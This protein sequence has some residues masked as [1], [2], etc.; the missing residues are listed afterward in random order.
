MQKVFVSILNFNGRDN[1]IDCLN[2]LK[3]VIEKN[4]ELFLVVID[5]NSKE[6]LNLPSF[7]GLNIKI[8]ENNSNLGFSGGHNVGIKYSLENGA[9]FVV[10]LNN[11]TVVDKNFILELLKVQNSNKDIGITSPKIYFAPGFEFHK[12]KYKK[13]DK[14]RVFW[15]AGG[16]MDWENMLGHHRG[17]DEVDKGQFDKMEETDFASG[18]CMMVK[19]EVFERIGF[20]DERF[21]LYYEDSDLCEKTKRAGFKLVYNPKAVIWHKNAASVGGSGSNLQD[22]YITRNRLLFA[23]KNAP[24]RLKISLYRESIKLLLSGRKWQKKGVAD[25]YLNKFGKGSYE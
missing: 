2:S 1:T 11:D 24:L 20:F 25:F 12:K 13:Q 21:F 18:C 9:D 19:K 14:G 16:K 8:I 4:F 7:P 15:Y 17:V 6:K 5:N 22:Y 10:I 23:T 3:E